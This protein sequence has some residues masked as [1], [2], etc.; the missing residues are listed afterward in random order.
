MK[1]VA[2]IQMATSPNVLANLFEAE[3]IIADAAAEGAQLVVLP[4]NFA[5]MGKRDEE[6]L[7]F[8]EQD[9][10]GP[11]QDFL[12]LM[13]QRYRL[14]V[15]GGTIPLM[16]KT[17]DKLRSACLVFDDRGHRQGRYDKIHLFDVQV[18]ET[19]ERYQESA[20]IEPGHTPCVID[21]PFGRLGV[22]VCYDL[23]FPELFRC[24]LDEGMEVMVMPAAFT[25]ATGR[26]HWEILIRARAIENLCYVVA[27]A[28]GGYHISGRETYG[29]SLIVDPW[30][31][32][33]ARMPR[34]SGHVCAALDKTQQMMV[35]KTFPVL[36]H[37]LH[38]SC[39][40]PGSA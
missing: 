15:V 4:E 23:R 28:Q 36:Q 24:L 8:R 2:A 20:T 27:G 1:K 9:G 14:W 21:S 11:L 33:L 38:L 19:N 29:N 12:A 18:M 6:L 17:P 37:R 32:I 22:A 13:A 34:G 10:S 39:A 5:F 7:A 26:A 30:G 35:R 40:K 25:A 16:A 3:R 31:R